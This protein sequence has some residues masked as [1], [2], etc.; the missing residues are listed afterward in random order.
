MPEPIEDPSAHEDARRVRK[1]EPISPAVS[2]VSV[3]RKKHYVCPVD[4]PVVPD[5][6]GNPEVGDPP[7]CPICGAAVAHGA[8]EVAPH[9]NYTTLVGDRPVVRP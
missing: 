4:G 5:H 3:P 6:L 2:H 1:G 8:Q 7:H 9:D